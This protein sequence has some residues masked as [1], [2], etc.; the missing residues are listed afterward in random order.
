MSSE[1]PSPFTIPEPAFV[2]SEGPSTD[3][4]SVR[5]LTLRLLIQNLRSFAAFYEH[6]TGEIHAERGIMKP[7]Y[8]GGRD[9]NAD[10]LRKQ[11]MAVQDIDRI[12]ALTL[13]RFGEELTIGSAQRLLGELLRTGTLTTDQALNLTLG[14]AADKLE[15]AASP[16]TAPIPGGSG[17]DPSHSGPGGSRVGPA[18]NGGQSPPA[19][20]SAGAATAPIDGGAA[21]ASRPVPT[22]DAMSADYLAADEAAVRKLGNAIYVLESGFHQYGQC[23]HHPS[24][25]KLSWKETIDRFVCLAMAAG[26]ELNRHH[27]AERVAGLLPDSITDDLR[28]DETSAAAVRGLIRHACAGDQEG[29]A[30]A[31]RDLIDSRM[32][33]R[34]SIVLFLL[35]LKHQATK[36]VLEA[37]AERYRR[38]WQGV[39][40]PPAGAPAGRETAD[41]STTAD[42]RNAGQADAGGTEAD[43][44]SIN[45]TPPNDALPDGPFEPRGFRFRGA[46][47][48]WGRAKLRQKLTLALWDTE[49]GKPRP[50]RSTQEVIEEVYGPDEETME[51][52]FRGLV[53]DTRG[54]YQKAK[55]ALD[56]K[57]EQGQIWLVILPE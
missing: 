52:T 8:I 39:D 6:S 50:P 38:Y 12:R 51:P 40:A 22:K 5:P 16:A 54:A 24:R 32:I 1:P 37:N 28:P 41:E 13:S 53:S 27:L 45:S 7:W 2:F 57:N 42:A 56:L 10:F 18:P 31:F 55:L 23:E 34:H 3:P 4:P 35:Q 46:S 21:G 44:A 30:H 15:P 19:A 11:F 14:E 49:C 26:E 17:F 47:L 29:L 20:R 33:F 9:A 48:F 25:W 36:W 43:R